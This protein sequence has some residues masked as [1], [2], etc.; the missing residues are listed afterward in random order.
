MGKRVVV[1]LAVAAL[2]AMVVGCARPATGYLAQRGADLADCF[3]GRVGYGFPAYV[4]VKATDF[5]VAGL[6]TATAYRVGWAGRYRNFEGAEREEGLPLLFNRLSMYEGE[7]VKEAAYSE[8]TLSPFS[9]IREFHP[10]NSARPPAGGLTA[11][12]FWLR[13]SLTAGPSVSVGFNLAEFVDFLVGL[14]TV[15]ILGDDNWPS[16]PAPTKAEKK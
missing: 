11:E 16:R 8:E 3:E 5:L 15:D 1:C 12:Q 6:G 9:T 4:G 13:A 2:G 7:V 10:K 14:T